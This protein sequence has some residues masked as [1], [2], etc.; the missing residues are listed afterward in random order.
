M[1]SMDLEVSTNFLWKC[2]L[3]HPWISAEVLVEVLGGK[4]KA[5]I[6]HTNGNKDAFL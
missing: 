1:E 3:F 2:I 4:G 5:S 6:N